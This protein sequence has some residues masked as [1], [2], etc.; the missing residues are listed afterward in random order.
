MNEQQWY[1]CYHW[2]S[3][4]WQI[5]KKKDNSNLW[6]SYFYW[7]HFTEGKTGN[8]SRLKTWTQFTQPSRLSTAFPFF[9]SGQGH[10]KGN[11]LVSG[12]VGPPGV[13]CPVLLLLPPDPSPGDREL[14][15]VRPVCAP[16]PTLPMSF[17]AVRGLA[18]PI[19]SHL[20]LQWDPSCTVPFPADSGHRQ[21]C[22][23]P[24]AAHTGKFALC[25]L[26]SL[27]DFTLSLTI[28]LIYPL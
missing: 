17:R 14:H 24:P 20:T 4:L 1:W 3:I 6:G 27:R 23:H 28:R 8:P 9:R 21:Q 7:P 12:H 11:P 5:R 18:P 25:K 13:A 2:V 22:S 26:Y 15:R 10:N 16:N 19:Q